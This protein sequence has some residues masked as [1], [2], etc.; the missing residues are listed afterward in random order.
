MYAA[1]ERDV[2]V[3]SG[4]VLLIEE[5]LKNDLAYARER[6]GLQNDA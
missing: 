4:R 6:L 5:Y 3:V 1:F 2:D